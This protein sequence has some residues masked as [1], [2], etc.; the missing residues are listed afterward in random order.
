MS[1]STWKGPLRA[2]PPLASVLGLGAGGGDP[3]FG[4]WPEALLYRAGDGVGASSMSASILAT[5]VR[6]VSTTS[7]D[8]VGDE[9]AIVSWDEFFGA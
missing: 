3:G 6:G 4:A 8:N 9:V 2:L 7:A 5:L 1:L